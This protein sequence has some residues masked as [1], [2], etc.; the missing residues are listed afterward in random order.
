M[1]DPIRDRIAARLG[2]THSIERELGGGGMARVF[3]ATERS[4]G[5][6]VVIKTLP[7]DSWTAS[8]AQRFHREILTAA[9]LQ[10]AHIVPVL[11]AGDADGLPWF[12]MPWVDGPSL[13]ERLA[14]GPVPLGEAVSI[15]RD[16]ARALSAAHAKNIV[17][18]DIK[19]ENILLS[20]GAALV[21]DFG[22]AKAVSVA[23]QAETSSQMMTT[24][25][26]SMGTPAY[27]SPEQIA[28]D[29]T[30]DHRTDIYAWGVVAYELLSGHRPFAELSGT[31]LV[32]AQ[33]GKQPPALR[34]VMPSVPAALSALVMRCLAKSPSERP[35]TATELLV[36]L[37]LPSGE[38]PASSLQARKRR[39]LMAA[40]AAIV[41][42]AATAWSVWGG[43]AASGDERVIAVAPFRVGGAAADAQYLREGLA[44][45]IVPQLQTLP[46][47]SPAS[48]RVVLDRWRRA[49]GSAEADLDDEGARRVATDAGAGQLLLGEIVGTANRLT[50]SARI[51]RVRDG[52]LLS[53]GRAEGSADSVFALATRLVTVLLSVRDGASQERLRSVLSAQPEAITAYLR[54]EQFYRRGRYTEAGKS[55]AQAYDVDTTFAIAALRLSSTNAWSFTPPI[56]G[57]WLNRAWTHRSRLTGTDSLLL[58]ASVGETY[59][60][61]MSMRARIRS[62][63]S[64]AKRSNTAEIWYYYADFI[65]HNGSNAGIEDEF[66][67]A[68]DGFRRAEALDSSF[69][70][71]L[72]HQPM[73]LLN[74][75][76]TVGAKAALARQAARDSSGDFFR[77]SD[78]RMSASLSDE[79]GKLAALRKFAAL[80]PANT[81]FAASTFGSDRYNQLAQ[82]ALADS[83]LRIANRLQ[84]SLPEASGINGIAREVAW[85]SGRPAKG[86]DVPAPRDDAHELML[87]VLATLLSDG[88][89]TRAMESVASLKGLAVS[90]DLSVADRASAYFALGLWAFARGDTAAVESAQR[91][92]RGIPVPA[93][94]PWMGAPVTIYGQ[95]LEAHLAVARRSPDAKARL[96]LIDSMLMDAPGVNRYVVRSAGN[97]LVSALWEATGE[98]ARALSAVK[99]RDGQFAYGMFAADRHRRTAR[100]AEQLGRREE[101]MASLRHFIAMRSGAESALRAEVDQARERLK[102]LEAAGR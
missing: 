63:E 31:A 35:Q 68:L 55:F 87:E 66:T 91:G 71:A 10:H 17:H 47:L 11:S 26:V 80:D 85:N 58:I 51:I 14:R 76:D 46:D 29:P 86:R 13:R 2:D 5:R 23:T 82:M 53:Q 57:P 33:M 81:P 56:P 16:V 19:P 45:I 4:L 88:D 77:I 20:A 6:Q 7:D 72:E 34:S 83:A 54:G 37:D 67:P 69:V 74:M 65:L 22:V 9:Q 48:M 52:R 75:N 99:R 27:M 36:A 102:R 78:F 25:G 21:T 62:L 79:A 3:L 95:L 97:F 60:T 98:P 12:T 64:L 96:A 38:S 94:Q 28:A 84:P 18:R 70:S 92:L 30:L 61:P 40:A 41:V 24:L 100:L 49:A 1:Q 39:G 43:G 15:L 8:A 44:D 89:S 73:I 90:T 50:V 59:P 101:A 42:I 93:A 32:Q